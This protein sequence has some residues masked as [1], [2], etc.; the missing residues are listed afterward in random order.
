M[1][2]IDQIKRKRK[3]LIVDISGRHVKKIYC[4]DS[5]SGMVL[6]HLSLLDTTFRGEIEL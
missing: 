2:Y 6:V 4:L 1:R 5:C 3:R